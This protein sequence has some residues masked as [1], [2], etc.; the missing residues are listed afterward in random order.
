VLDV[1]RRLARDRWVR[2]HGSPR[3][4][5]LAGGAAARNA[6]REWTALGGSG[7]DA[8]TLVD[9]ELDAALREAVAL[10]EADPGRDVAVIASVPA[11]DR[12]RATAPDRLRAL[13]DEG[14]VFV[15]DPAQVFDAR[16][17]A[18]A[19]LHEAL[20]L[21]PTTAG[22]FELNGRLSFRFGPDAA[23]VDLLDRAARIAIEVDGHH[24]FADLDRYRRDRRKDVALQAHGYF[25]VRVLAIDVMRDP[26]AAVGVVCQALAA[27]PEPR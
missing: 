27:R 1:L 8:P 15:P 5:V 6:W 2:V 22:R 19:L 14:L 11:L 23:E 3:V 7:D 18:E 20:E 16:S 25:V 12:W 10:A 13:V 26:R 24:H 21:T 17:A 4:T 9:G